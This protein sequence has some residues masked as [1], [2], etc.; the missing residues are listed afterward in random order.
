MQVPSEFFYQLQLHHEKLLQQYDHKIDEAQ[1]LARVVCEQA[2]KAST[3]QG[4]IDE[5][6]KYKQMKAEIYEVCKLIYDQQRHA[7][8]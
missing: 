2:A 3:P 7:A 4:S 5:A 8:S 6:K 1:I